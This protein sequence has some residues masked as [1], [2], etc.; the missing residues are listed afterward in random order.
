MYLATI[1]TIV[2]W[3]LCQVVDMIK[4]EWTFLDQEVN[5]R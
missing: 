3:K 4:P 2:G 5:F 1:E